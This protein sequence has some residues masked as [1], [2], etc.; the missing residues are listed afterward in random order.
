M[1]GYVTS[2]KVRQR[3]PPDWQHALMGTRLEPTYDG[4]QDKRTVRIGCAVD[5]ARRG[6]NYTGSYCGLERIS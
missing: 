3:K 1:P 6:E 4:L 2:E 5:T